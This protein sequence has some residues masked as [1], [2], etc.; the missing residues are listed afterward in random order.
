MKLSKRNIRFEQGRDMDIMQSVQV[1]EVMNRKPRT[2]RKTQSLAE[3]Y[4]QFQETNFLGF[5][6]L[7]EQDSLW[8]FVSLQDLEKTLSQPTINLRGLKVEDIAT[9]NPTTVFGDEP[10]W[11]AIQKMAP[12]DLARLPV[13]SRSS[14]GK[15]LGLISRSDILRAYDV[16]IVRK[17]RGQLL[18]KHTNLRQEQHND[19]TEFHL[20]AGHYAVGKKLRDMALSDPIIVVSI[21]REGVLHIPHG[22]ACFAAGDIITLFGRKNLLESAEDQFFSGENDQ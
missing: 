18:E 3:L 4:Q 10:I 11:A 9:V 13:V 14:K 2:I 1:R 12:R 20:K 21:D 22:N 19:F 8:G 15:L 5:P 6:V 16:G 7:D 17:Q